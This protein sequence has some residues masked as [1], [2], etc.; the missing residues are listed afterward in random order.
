MQYENSVKAELA[1]AYIRCVRA[2]II[3]ESGKFTEVDKSYDDLRTKC[4]DSVIENNS[5]V[6]LMKKIKS[7][8]IRLATIDVALTEDTDSKDWTP[9]SAPKPFPK[10]PNNQMPHSPLWDD[11]KFKPDKDAKPW[12]NKFMYG[13][14]DMNN[15][16]DNQTPDSKFWHKVD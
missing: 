15:G 9:M 7:I 6:D 2:L 8:L 5:A 11:K 3:A 4:Y 10:I 12:D 13:K 16:S 1:E 14:A